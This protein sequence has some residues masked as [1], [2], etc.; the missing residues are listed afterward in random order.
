[1]LASVGT[2]RVLEL[3]RPMMSA[4]SPVSAASSLSRWRVNSAG[5]LTPRQSARGRA[6]MRR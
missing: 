6:A 4:L 2:G 3:V 5:V 1:M